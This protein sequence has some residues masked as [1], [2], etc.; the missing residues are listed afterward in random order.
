[1]ASAELRGL[2]ALVTGAAL[3]ASEFAPA[4][5]LRTVW[6]GTS[7]AVA[8][9]TP[10]HPARAMMAAPAIPVALSRSPSRMAARMVP[11]RGSSRVSKAAVLAAADRRPRKY[12]V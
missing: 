1:M 3:V 12:S 5:A 9:P 7:G 10:V 6:P 11:V 4:E 2:R 8:V